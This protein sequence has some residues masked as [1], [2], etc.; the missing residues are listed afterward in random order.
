MR[1]T[2]IFAAILSSMAA[3]VSGAEKP[4]LIPADK[5]YTAPDAQPLLNGSVLVRGG[6]VVG[7]ADQHARLAIPKGTQT[8]DCRGVV[9][10]GFQ[11]SHVHFMEPVWNDAAHADARGLSNSLDAMLTKYGYTTVFD[12]GSDQANTVALR[13]RLR[14]DVRGPRVLTVGLPLYPVDGLPIYIADMPADVLAR[15]HQPKSADEARANVRANLA[16]GADG[17]KLFLHTSHDGKTPRF[18]TLDV[19]RAAVEETHAQGKLVLAHPTSLEAVRAAIVGG[20]DV[21]VHTTLGEKDPWD[22]AVVAQLIQH[23]VSV[24]PTFKLWVYELRK[25]DVPPP[26][27]DKLV[28]ATLEE[29]RAFHTAG[30][31]VL[32]GTD[33]GYMHDYDPTDEYMFMQKAGMTPAQILASLTTAP[34]ARW[35]ES[36]RRGRVVPGADADLVVLGGDPAEDVKNFSNVRCVFRAGTLIYDSKEPR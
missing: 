17:T 6:R 4:L 27:I 3:V 30:G 20:V 1:A 12:T 32:F 26:V 25:Q 24:I 21:L 22:A 16:N 35:K 8:S 10:A 18:M 29:L 33:V 9:V 14:K 19:I 23:H 28:A 31:Q 15:M 36:E 5:I 34:A 13:E 7:V 2:W 11:N